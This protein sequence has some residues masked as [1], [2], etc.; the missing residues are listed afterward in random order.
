MNLV[1]RRRSR[2]VLAELTQ[3]APRLSQSPFSTPNHI[4]VAAHGKA[5]EPAEGLRVLSDALGF[6]EQTKEAYSAAELHRLT[7]E[8]LLQR[9]RTDE[10]AAETAYRTA[11]EIS[12]A[13]R[14]KSWELR[15]VTSLARLWRDQGKRTEAHD[16]LAPT[17]GWFT[18]GF[19]TPDLQEAKA[20]LDELR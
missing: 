4:L 17:Y 12:R 16:L 18:E 5:G 8:L 13:Q 1:A 11:I 9:G 15:A 3:P 7:G 20:L 14:A 19:G 6:V 10:P 2:I